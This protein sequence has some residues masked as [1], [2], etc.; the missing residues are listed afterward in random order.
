MKL[1][2]ASILFGVGMLW[3]SSFVLGISFML[4]MIVVYEN[5]K[6]RKH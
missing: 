2:W 6:V 3:D 5:L 4:S 1:M